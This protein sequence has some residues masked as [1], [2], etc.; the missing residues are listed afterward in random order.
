MFDF[1]SLSSETTS[2]SLFSLWYQKQNLVFSSSEGF[3]DAYIKFKKIYEERSA[4]K[5]G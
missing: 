2:L 1:S 3:I 4:K 5:N